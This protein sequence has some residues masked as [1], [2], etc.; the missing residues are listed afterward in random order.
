MDEKVSAIVK[1]FIEAVNT[2]DEFSALINFTKLR[3]LGL[4][5]EDLITKG[6][7]NVEPAAESNKKAPR[8]KGK[9]P[10][11]SRRSSR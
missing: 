7:V 3:N 9:S 2:G 10:S 4:T 11:K 8:N 1:A 6:Y 5:E